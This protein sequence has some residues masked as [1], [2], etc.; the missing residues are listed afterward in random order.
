VRRLLILSFALAVTCAATPAW[1]QEA[2]S[3]AVLPEPTG[4]DQEAESEEPIPRWAKEPWQKIRYG[5]KGG[6]AWSA[7]AGELPIPEVGTFGFRADYGFAAGLSFEIPLSQKV[8]LQPEAL[9]VRKHAALDLSET[10][11]TG[12]E[13]LSVNYFEVP[14]LL[15]WYPGERRGT[16]FSLVGGPA[17]GLRMDARRESRLPNGSITDHEG[18][19]LVRATDWGM[20]VG[21]GVEFHEFIWA[22]TV[23]LRY[24]HGL[25]SIDNSGSGNSPKWRAIYVM[26]G[27][28]W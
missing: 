24:N 3:G 23:D 25:S 5:V 27:V 8:S 17:V 10:T 7:L 12:T 1:A 19:T 11:Y 9:I 2:D 18:K 15:K 22:L 28:S 6:A 13:K 16:I 14:I 21:A 26:A 20:M 4:A